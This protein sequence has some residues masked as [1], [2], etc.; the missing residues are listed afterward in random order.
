[1][2]L[3]KTISTLL[4]LLILLISSGCATTIEGPQRVPLSKLDIPDDAFRA[5]VEGYGVKYA[6]EITE[7]DCSNSG[8][9]DL[10]G[11]KSFPN[12]Q[13]AEFSGNR[14]DDLKET[15][16]EALLAWDW[17][18]DQYLRF[19]SNKLEDH[20]YSSGNTS[21][22]NQYYVKFAEVPP[23]T[24]FPNADDRCSNSDFKGYVRIKD[25]Q[26]T[27]EEW[28]NRAATPRV[29]DLK[30][31]SS[32]SS[33]ASTLSQT[34]NRYT[35]HLLLMHSGYDSGSS[36]SLP[37]VQVHW[38]H[39]RMHELY[40]DN[41][42]WKYWYLNTYW[43][44]GQSEERDYWPK[45]CNETHDPDCCQQDNHICD[46]NPPISW[47]AAS[48]TLNSGE[49]LNLEWTM[50]ENDNPTYPEQ[51]SSMAD[52]IVWY[53]QENLGSVN[54]ELDSLLGGVVAILIVLYWGNDDDV[55]SAS[56]FHISHGAAYALA[57]D[58]GADSGNPL[59]IDRVAMRQFDKTQDFGDSNCDGN[60]TWVLPV[61]K[62]KTRG[63]VETNYWFNLQ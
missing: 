40:N 21:Q 16:T 50:A 1:M 38:Q 28:T 6:D 23:D 63:A 4:I 34:N 37:P 53:Q 43:N 51:I 26:T 42:N 47:D 13:V 52:A 19:D 25:A 60:E 46:S 45:K 12:L 5:C 11:I 44:K 30:D 39:E 10:R 7:L 33:L 27:D 29:I 32:L 22:F 14:Y 41:D 54:N 55:L 3:R 20:S 62:Y 8:I 57:K 2:L 17:Y 59:N 48:V 24:D 9:K 49:G 36:G 61:A 56:H 31:V 58:L 15:E 35:R 18:N